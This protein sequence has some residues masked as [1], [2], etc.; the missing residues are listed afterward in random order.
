MQARRDLVPLAGAASSNDV[1]GWIAR[2]GLVVGLSLVD[3][4][5]PQHFE[6]LTTE[7]V[8]GWQGW[9][10]WLGVEMASGWSRRGDHSCRH[11]GPQLSLADG[12][13]LT[14][15]EG[16]G[17]AGSRLASAEVRVL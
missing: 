7:Q 3:L 14:K 17:S 11:S 15:P 6:G 9:Q 1:L 16:G 4:N 10:G 13:G 12:E 2:Q 5:Y 8:R